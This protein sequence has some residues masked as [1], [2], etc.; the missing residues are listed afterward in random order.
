[1]VQ[2][3]V[4]AEMKGKSQR[5]DADGAGVR[6]HVADTVRA[7]QYGVVRAFSAPNLVM[8]CD[9]VPHA[10]VCA[11]LGQGVV[12]CSAV[13]SGAVSSGAVPS[14]AVLIGMV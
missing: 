6:V 7:V 2:C 3:V 13:P 4:E 8:W 11:Q 9:I 12:L 1:M 14:G 5:A 10:W